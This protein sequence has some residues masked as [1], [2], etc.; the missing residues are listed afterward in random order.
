MSDRRLPV[1][2][3]L[4]QLKHQAKDLL[5]AIRR[6]DPA[7][8][9]ELQ[10]YHPRPPAPDHI[11]LADAQHAVTRRRAGRASSCRVS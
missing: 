5:R 8:L 9:A 7:A 11:K 10:Q 6:S 4:K 3:D 1:R 2:P